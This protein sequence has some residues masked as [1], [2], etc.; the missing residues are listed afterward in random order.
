VD[1]VAVAGAPAAAGG[2]LLTPTIQLAF[3]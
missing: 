3:N 1:V 2:T